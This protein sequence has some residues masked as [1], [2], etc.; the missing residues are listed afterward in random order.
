[1]GSISLA[2]RHDQYLELDNLGLGAFSPVVN[3]M[4]E[5]EFQSV[6]E[7]MYLPSGDPFTLPVVL[8]VDSAF[9]DRARAASTMRPTA[10]S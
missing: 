7:T 6:C 3:F 2:L 4:N 1:M 8:D 10:A 5:E 9:A